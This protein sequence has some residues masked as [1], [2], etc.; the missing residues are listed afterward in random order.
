MTAKRIVGASL[1]LILAACALRQPLPAP[2]PSLAA[3]QDS[4]WVAV[5]NR[6]FSRPG[7]DSIVLITDSTDAPVLRLGRDY[8]SLGPADPVS[9]SL[10]LENFAFRNA[11][12]AG[13]D[14]ERLAAIG[15]IKPIAAVTDAEVLAAGSS[16]GQSEYV[17]ERFPGVSFVISLSQ[18]GFDATRQRALVRTSGSCGPR[19]GGTSLIFLSRSPSG[20]WGVDRTERGG[21]F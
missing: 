11:R 18:A 16:P 9:D 7:T 5:L 2:I 19:C 17:F 14:V 8:H 13:V 20:G 12:R 21:Q 10:L 3:V 4:V 1:L 15:T 6:V